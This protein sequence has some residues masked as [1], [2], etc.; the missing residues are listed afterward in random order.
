MKIA[1][2]CQQLKNNISGRELPTVKITVYRAYSVVM[3]M[4]LGAG[5]DKKQTSYTKIVMTKLSLLV[6]FNSC[7]KA[8]N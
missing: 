8:K 3:C 6:M 5:D 4:K 2:S 1:G 7:L